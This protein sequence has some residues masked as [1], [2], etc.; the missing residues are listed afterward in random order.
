MVLFR[1]ANVRQREKECVCALY[2]YLFSFLHSQTHT[3]LWN[4]SVFRCLICVYI[5]RFYVCDVF[6]MY[7]H[8]RHCAVCT[9]FYFLLLF[10]WCV[11]FFLFCFACL[12]F[13]F[14]S[15]RFGVL[16]A[17]SKLKRF[18]L[19][20]MSFRSFIRTTQTKYTALHIAA[21]NVFLFRIR[22]VIATYIAKDNTKALC[23]FAERKIS[24][25]K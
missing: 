16:S 18:P 10:S 5:V 4:P 11:F 2:K 19:F 7:Y 13:S 20:A 8:Y 3:F 6:L 17:L 23:V 12:F 21:F 1:R 14:A 22:P 9:A 15:I 24:N 25:T